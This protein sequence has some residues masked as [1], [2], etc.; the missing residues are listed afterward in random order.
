MVIQPTLTRE[1]ST[2]SVSSLYDSCSSN[3]QGYYPNQKRV[4][5]ST[6]KSVSFDITKTEYIPTISNE[7]YTPE[8]KIATFYSRQEYQEMKDSIKYLVNFLRYQEYPRSQT[9]CKIDFMKED[10]VCV[11]GL[12]CLADEF[13]S[14]HRKRIRQLSLTAVFAF[15]NLTTSHKGHYKNILGSHSNSSF[16][17][18]YK[19]ESIAKAYMMHTICSQGI[20]SR[21]GHFDALDAD[22]IHNDNTVSGSSSTSTRGRGSSIMTDI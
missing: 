20:A 8:E 9:K 10:D 6:K 16:Y 7:D 14:M 21:W 12:E 11:R 4:R 3:E 1:S 19:S 15:Q 2:R 22:T 5:L 17:N 13:V 18:N